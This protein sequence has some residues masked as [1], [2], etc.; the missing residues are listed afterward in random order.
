MR[1][2]KVTKEMCMSVKHL[3]KSGTK[4]NQIAK[5]FNC[6]VSTVSNI[7]K[8]GYEFDEYKRLMRNQF[9]E[10]VNRES[11]KETPSIFVNPKP[12]SVTILDISKKVDDLTARFNDAVVH[13][14]KRSGETRDLL[15]SIL[16]KLEKVFV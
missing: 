7:K 1:K 13:G 12:V 11:L 6:S 4:N 16:E 10:K 15:K 9:Q 5:A 3:V 2:G 14:S 8:S